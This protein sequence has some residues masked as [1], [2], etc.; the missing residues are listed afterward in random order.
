MVRLNEGDRFEDSAINATFEVLEDVRT[1]GM[2]RSE[3]DTTSVSV[4]WEDG[5]QATIPVSRIKR[6]DVTK[7]NN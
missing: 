2:S 5:M 7:V 1:F 3:V 4:E 6:S